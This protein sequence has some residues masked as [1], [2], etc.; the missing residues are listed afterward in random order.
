MR[1]HDTGSPTSPP[2]S[3][4]IRSAAGRG[5]SRRRSQ[6]RSSAR[7]SVLPDA[8]ATA[9]GRLARRAARGRARASRQRDGSHAAPRSLRA[10]RSTRSSS[11]RSRCA[12]IALAPGALHYDPYDQLRSR[13]L[14]DAGPAD[15]AGA[16]AGRCAGR[17]RRVRA[18]P[19]GASSGGRASSTAC[20][21]TASRCSRRVTWRRTSLLAAAALG[22]AGAARWAASTTRRL[23]A[24]LGRRRR[25]RV[26]RSTSF[27]SAAARDRRTVVWAALGACCR[28]IAL[29]ARGVVAAPAAPGASGR[30][31]V[32]CRSAWRAGVA[33]F[34]VAGAR[35]PPPVPRPLAAA[36]SPS[37]PRAE[38]VVWRW[39]LLGELAR[40]RRNRCRRSHRELAALFGA[41]HPR[42]TPRSTSRPE[43]AFGGVY[44]TTGSLLAAWGAHA[45][46]NVCCRNGGATSACGGAMSVAEPKRVSKRYGDVVA[47]DAV[48]AQ[49]RSRLDGRAPRAE[50]RRQ[51]DADL[52][53][54]RPAHARLRSA[55]QCSAATRARPAGARLAR[56]APQDVGFP[57]TLRWS[58]LVALR[59]RPLRAGGAC[60]RRARPVRPRTGSPSGRPAGSRAGQRR[61]LGARPR[62]RRAA[63]ARDP[64]RADRVAS[65]P[66]ARSAVWAAVSGAPRAGGGTVAARDPRPGRGRS[67]RR[68]GRASSTPGASWPT[69]SRA[70][71]RGAPPERHASPIAAQRSPPAFPDASLGARTAWCSTSATAGAAVARLVGA[72]RRAAR[73]R[74][75][76]A[77]ARGGVAQLERPGS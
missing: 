47:L 58:E 50:R 23:D 73:A 39:F 25:R 8:A 26:V 36:C 32:G 59:G 75:A 43:L 48:V 49:R 51:D 52:A 63:A 61:R 11:T 74:G 20:A 60:R 66:T 17:S 5:R 3:R 14:T 40:A 69:A 19:H 38:E 2:S 62:V 28:R 55:S 16:V 9:V 30:T 41:V 27:S 54:A 1:Q 71:P 77:V 29:A 7:R 56:R 22:A 37:P 68:P 44:V 70:S 35:A 24:L 53:A 46:Y 34:A 33:L 57:A 31:A 64:G 65:T 15:L 21:A 18:R 45:A 10:V 42:P 12:S 72:R 13:R 76:P 67:R 6:R 4:A